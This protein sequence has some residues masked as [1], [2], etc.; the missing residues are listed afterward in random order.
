MH[1]LGYQFRDQLGD[2]LWDQ[3]SD[4]LGNQLRGQLGNQLWNQ[5]WDQLWD[6]LG[7]QLGY[8]LGNQLGNQ[9]RNQLRNQLWDQLGDQLR[10]QL[11][12]QL[13]NQLDQFSLQYYTW[14]LYVSELE[15]IKVDP[16]LKKL[17]QLVYNLGEHTFWILPY[18]DKIIFCDRPTKLYFNEN[19]RLHSLDGEPAIEFLDGYQ[20]YAWNGI[21][22]D[23]KI[24]TESPTREDLLTNNLEVRRILWER[25]GTNHCIQ[26]LDAKFVVSDEWGELWSADTGDE[27]ETKFVKVINST[28]EPDGSFKDYWLRVPPETVSARAGIG[29]TFDLGAEEYAPEVMT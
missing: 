21:T 11:W 8:Q 9:L 28:P 4:Q 1:Q 16:K 13:E 20:L 24:I 7:Y 29:W 10:H 2:Q 3:L 22:V 19:K 14:M 27:E 26:L 5:L 18:E 17:S 12:N 6:Q 25:W 23:K 15:D